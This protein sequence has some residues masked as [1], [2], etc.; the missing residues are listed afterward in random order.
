MQQGYSHPIRQTTAGSK[1]QT[2]LVLLAERVNAWFQYLWDESAG[3]VDRMHRERQRLQ[4]LVQE[5]ELRLAVLL[6]D[7]TD[8]V[9]VTDDEHRFLAVNRAALN[10]FGVSEKNIPKFTMDAFLLGKETRFFDRTVPRFVRGAKRRGG[11]RIRRLDG[12]FRDVKFTFQA[13]F[14]FGRHL[15]VLRDVTTSTTQNCV[16]LV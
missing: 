11:C 14:V 6:S 13:N 4:G 5:R 9:V 7:S 12:C 2:L 10:L 8:A 15:S 1:A 16:T 3:I